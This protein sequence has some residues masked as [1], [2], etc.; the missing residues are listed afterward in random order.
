MKQKTPNRFRDYVLMA[1]YAIVLIILCVA[2]GKGWVDYSVSTDMFLVGSIFVVLFGFE[3]S[4]LYFYEEKNIKRLI[5]LGFIWGV[6]A[7]LAIRIGI[8]I[9]YIIW[10]TEKSPGTVGHIFFDLWGSYLWM[11]V[12]GMVCMLIKPLLDLW[13][14]KRKSVGVLE[15]SNRIYDKDGMREYEYTYIDDF[16]IWHSDKVIA[17]SMEDAKKNILQKHGDET[18]VEIWENSKDYVENGKWWSCWG[19]F[20]LWPVRNKTDELVYVWPR[21]HLFS[22]IFFLLAAIGAFISGEIFPGVLFSFFAL[23]TFSSSAQIAIRRDRILYKKRFFAKKKCKE[24]DIVNA[25][26]LL[27][28]RKI[29]EPDLGCQQC[30][31]FIY[32]EKDGSEILIY[33]GSEIHYVRKMAERIGHFLKLPVVLVENSSKKLIS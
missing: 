11:G 12:L 23:L 6:I 33:G 14:R 26:K 32:V 27:L 9:N 29:F 17:G 25:I 28:K 18:P 20:Y 3:Y 22:K 2:N 4:S 7:N 21:L 31:A 5:R 24:I 13:R 16:Q 30:Y 1:A 15:K 10:G 8:V 19:A